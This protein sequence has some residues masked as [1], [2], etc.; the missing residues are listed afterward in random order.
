MK[1][2]RMAETN[3]A[4][5]ELYETLGLLSERLNFAKRFDEAAERQTK[6]IKRLKEQKPVVFVTAVAGVA[7]AVGAATWLI[8]K[9]SISHFCC[10][11]R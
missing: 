9:K 8:A 5:A 4:R 11:R 7:T 1:L 10:N 2:E 6:K 3:H